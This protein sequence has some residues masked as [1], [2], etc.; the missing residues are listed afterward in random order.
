MELFYV[1]AAAA[2]LDFAWLRWSSSAHAGRVLS[3]ALWAVLVGLL[4]LIGLTGAL[5]GLEPAI[6]YLAGLGFGSGLAAWYQ[7]RRGVTP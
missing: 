5:R 2:V 6:A 7:S 4:G 1:F 3:S